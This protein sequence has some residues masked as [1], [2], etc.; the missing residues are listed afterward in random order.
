MANIIRRRRPEGDLP[1]LAGAG[2]LQLFRE[3]LGWDP[4]QGMSALPAPLEQQQL[5]MPDFEVQETPEA[6]VFRADLPGVRDEDLEISVRGNQ[7]VVNGK[8]E[9][10]QRN[11][12]DRF[13]VYERSYGSFTRTF[14]LPTGVDTD[15]IRAELSNGVLR[16]SIPKKP[17]HQHK[18][19]DVKPSQPQQQAGGKPE[20][21]KA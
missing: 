21:A 2:P 7:L 3:L 10:E 5:F 13:Y 4:F 11:E 9:A 14:T 17:E 16:L 6:F 20:K 8:R 12:G 1:S 18:K 15:N 19:I